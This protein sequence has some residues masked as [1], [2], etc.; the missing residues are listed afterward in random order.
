M[1]RFTANDDHAFVMADLRLRMELLELWMRA[2]LQMFTFSPYAEDTVEKTSP[3]SS[4]IGDICGYS[5][6]MGADEQGTDQRVERVFDELVYPTIKDHRGGAEGPETLGRRH[7]PV[8]FDSPVEAVRCA[9]IIQQSMIGRNLELSEPQWIRFRIGINLGDIIIEGSTVAGEGVNIAARLE[10]MADPG[11]IFISGGV[12]E[13]IRYKLVCGYQSLG[14]KR[15]KNITDPVPVYKVL[16][17]PTALAQATKAG[18]RRKRIVLATLGGIGLI[19]ALGAGVYATLR[20][21]D[22]PITAS[23]PAPAPPP[24]RLIEPA[25]IVRPEPPPV[26]SPIVAPPPQPAVIAPPAPIAEPPPPAIVQPAVAQP[27]V[28]APTPTPVAPDFSA[29]QPNRHKRQRLCVRRR[30]PPYRNRRWSPRWWPS[31]GVVFRWAV[32]MTQLKNRFIVSRLPHF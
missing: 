4:R 15:V 20:L 16:P 32:L 24:A 5:R 12:Y 8:I 7:Y 23:A 13:Q 19:L 31:P 3:R 11:Y 6:L 9:I 29:P 28:P 1:K 27:V 14:D 22:S 18:K 2:Y 21:A 17:D 30:H 26:D 25:R 10:A